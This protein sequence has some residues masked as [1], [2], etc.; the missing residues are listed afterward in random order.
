MTQDPFDLDPTHTQILATNSLPATDSTDQ[1]L[2]RRCMVVAFRLKFKHPHEFDSEDA[3][4]RNADESL[5][6]RVE[7]DSDFH[8]QMLAW[9][10]RG[11]VR[12]YGTGTPILVDSAPPVLKAAKEAYKT[13]NDALGG[14]IMD[15]CTV[16]SWPLI[17]L[18][19]CTNKLRQFTIACSETG[20]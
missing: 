5:P 19:Q 2:L 11:A 7:T 17:R 15:N 10:V 6:R 9:L 3:N 4:H 16:W 1:A 14:W 12:W 8:E 20:P 18:S 13:E